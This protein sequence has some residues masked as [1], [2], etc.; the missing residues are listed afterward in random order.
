[1]KS[2]AS[3]KDETAIMKLLTVTLNCAHNRL[4]SAKYLDDTELKEIADIHEFSSDD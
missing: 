4:G 1:M 2:L 3:G